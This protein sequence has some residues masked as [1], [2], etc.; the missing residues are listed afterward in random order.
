MGC[1]QLNL[2]KKIPTEH[3]NVE[4]LVHFTRSKYNEKTLYY[5]LLLVCWYYSFTQYSWYLNVLPK[6]D[7]WKDDETIFLNLSVAKNSKEII[8]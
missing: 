8:C 2:A 5:C 1:Q 6:M 4:H 7:K 3:F